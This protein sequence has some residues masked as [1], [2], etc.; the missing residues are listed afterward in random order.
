[1][2]AKDRK[3]IKKSKTDEN[4]RKVEKKTY[5]DHSKKYGKKNGTRVN[6]SRR[7]NKRT[8]KSKE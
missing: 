7:V 1:M 8:Q 4:I 6:E 2:K 5:Q 3:E